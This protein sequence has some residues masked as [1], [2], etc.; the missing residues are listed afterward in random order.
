MAKKGKIAQ[1]QPISLK[2][3]IVERARKLPFYKC[4]SVGD[5]ASG[6]NQIIVSRQKANGNIIVGFYLI[7]HFCLGLKDT[8]Y[9]EFADLDELDE[10]YFDSL[11]PDFKTKEISADY[12]Q[13]YIYGAIEYAEDLG[14]EPDKDF[15]ITEYILDDVEDIDYIE[16]AFGENGIPHYIP[17]EQ[18]D[19]EKNLKILREKV[20]MDNFQFTNLFDAFDDEE[21]Y[22]DDEYFDE[23]SK[24]K[25][26]DDEEFTEKAQKIIAAM[27]EGNPKL[28]F[29]L[30]YVV[31]AKIE[32]SYNDIDVLIKRYKADK[33]GLV[34]EIKTK[35]INE[36]EVF[37]EIL[38]KDYE[39]KILQT[40][41]EQYLYHESKHFILHTDY[42]KAISSFTSQV[43]SVEQ[44]H[45]MTPLKDKMLVW[46]MGMLDEI[47]EFL[48][49]IESFKD[50]D[51]DRQT[52]ALNY[53]MVE[54]NNTEASEI[55]EA[56]ECY[57][58]D[59]TTFN[60]DFYGWN[61][62]ELR[63]KLIK[64]GEDAILT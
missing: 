11:P 25:D 64:I 36:I 57:W 42:Q 14:F 35:I 30:N 62:Q 55:S 46:G 29:I 54:I 9:K 13:N 56:Y 7:D 5:D 4:W 28:L 49:K 18:D 34:N 16:I 51:L 52:Q 10:A 12:A 15:R 2:T 38:D 61:E 63:A 41:V 27:P 31:L 58:E 33:K 23:M 48:F 59:F 39:N 60:E 3:Y 45:L 53:F 20:G 8:F 19:V 22:D 37:K 6:M 32:S 50:L 24:L 43:F 40:L 1:M 17:G 26:L 21:K 44:F 47:S